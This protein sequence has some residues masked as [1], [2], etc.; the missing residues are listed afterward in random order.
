MLNLEVAILSAHKVIYIYVIRGHKLFFC[1]SLLLIIRVYCILVKG[2]YNVSVFL[3]VM[4]SR[5]LLSAFLN[6]P[7]LS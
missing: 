7:S 6:F 5:Y 4:S 2:S 3:Q 1:L